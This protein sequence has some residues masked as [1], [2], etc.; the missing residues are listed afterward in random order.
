MLYKHASNQD[1][2]LLLYILGCVNNLYVFMFSAV[3]KVIKA[4][5][6]MRVNTQLQRGKNKAQQHRDKS[7]VPLFAFANFFFPFSCILKAR[8]WST[9]CQYF[10]WVERLRYIGFWSNA[11]KV[12][13]GLCAYLNCNVKYTNQTESY[14]EACARTH[15]P[16]PLCPTDRSW[17]EAWR[18][19]PCSRLYTHCSV[20]LSCASITL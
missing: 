16:A 15:A 10:P 6:V 1:A 17:S 3:G 14:N 12:A 7:G 19:S 2:T 20:I 11:W 18:L 13:Q 8:S 9:V 5:W 4:V